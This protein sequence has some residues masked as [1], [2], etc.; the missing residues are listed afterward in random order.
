MS[1]A[2]YEGFQILLANLWVVPVATFIGIMVGAMPGLNSSNSLAIMLP[3]LMAMPVE[4]ALIFTVSLY[5]GAEVGGSYPAILVNIPGTGSAAVTAFDGYQ[6]NKNK[7]GAEALGISIFASFWGGVISGLISLTC[8]PLISKVALKVSSVE[9]AII[10]FFGVAVLAQLSFG[11]PAKGM[12]VGLFGLLLATTGVDPIWGHVRA[13]FGSMYLMDGIPTVPAMIGL[14]AFSEILT[15]LENPEG[16]EPA[17]QNQAKGGLKGIFWGF[18]HTMKRWGVTLRSSLIGTIVGAIPGAGASIASFIA[19]QQAI[20]YA[21]ENEKKSFGKGNPD[22]VV[23][24]EAANNGVGGGSLIPLLTLGVPGSASMAVLMVVMAYQGLAVGPRLFTQNGSIAYAALWSQFAAAV[25]ML[26]IGTAFAWSIYRIAYV[27]QNLLLPIISV[28]C[29]IGGF[30]P[31]RY[32]FDMALVI[33]FGIVGYI[34]KKYGY[35]PVALL[36][37]LVLGPLLEANIFR[38]LKIGLGSPLVFFTRPAAL[39]LWSI[40]ILTFIGPVLLRNLKQPKS[41]TVS[42]D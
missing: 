13:T 27:P 31:R 37:G 21:P 39:V 40:L 32:T 8:A 29:L 6:M 36:L 16:A 23:A 26:I 34:M 10:V 1:H 9:M 7:K 15:T 14:L 35:P 19:Y 38:G 4:I 2:I 30:A 33:V 42:N 20:V 11:G 18:A 28:V 17:R 24:S 12:L 41:T 22:G 25:F 5:C 3:M